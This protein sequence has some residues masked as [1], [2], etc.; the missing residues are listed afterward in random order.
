MKKVTTLALAMFSVLALTLTL[1]ACGGNDAAPITTPSPTPETTPVSTPEPAQ[2]EPESE[3]E[4]EEDSEPEIKQHTYPAMGTIE[5]N[6]YISEY[7]GFQLTLPDGWENGDI[8]AYHEAIANYVPEEIMD[9]IIDGYLPKEF[10]GGFGGFADFFANNPEV[11]SSLSINFK[12]LWEEQ[13]EFTEIDYI[14][15][16]ISRVNQLVQE[17]YTPVFDPDQIPV[18]IGNMEWYIYKESYERQFDTGRMTFGS[19]NYINLTNGYINQIILNLGYFPGS[20][21]YW[22][23]VSEE[24]LFSLFEISPLY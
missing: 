20:V 6:V 14:E 22:D 15:D 13:V 4:D 10:F 8:T 5:G 7:L 24:D 12:I 1:T 21:D 17:N 16:Q 19:I 11:R 2:E 23:I 18:R 3:E 9:S